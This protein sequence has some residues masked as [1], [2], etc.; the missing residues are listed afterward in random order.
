MKNK[1][2]KS[3]AIFILGT[4]VFAFGLLSCI[5]CNFRFIIFNIIM[6]IGILIESYGLIFMK[7]RISNKNKKNKS[8]KN[9]ETKK[10]EEEI[11]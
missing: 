2:L 6:F 9:N 7:I 10:K 4:I 1:T 11:I 8:T 3:N 5:I